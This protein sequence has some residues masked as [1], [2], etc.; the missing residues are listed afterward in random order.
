LRSWIDAAVPGRPAPT[1]LVLLPA[2]FQRADD[3]RA[4]GFVAAVRARG[5]DSDVVGVDL[6]F[7]HL[8]DRSV[9]P[10]LRSAVIEPARAAGC[11][12][13][14]LA[15]ISLGGYVAVAYAQRHPADVQGLCLLA[16]YLGARRVIGRIESA[17]G[18]AAWQPSDHEPDPEDA[19]LWRYLKGLRESRT[20][21][22]LG[23]GAGD[24]FAPAHELLAKGLPPA[25]V[26]RV[27]G[28]HGLMTWIRLWERFLDSGKF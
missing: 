27:P 10:A 28:G 22:Y 18:L 1:R 2:A 24:R 20:L 16:P 9:L 14:W 13:L 6:E 7:E 25:A 12:T 11:H 5:L 3:L 21:V 17:G 15:G 8:T 4:A 26:D 23:F 19:G